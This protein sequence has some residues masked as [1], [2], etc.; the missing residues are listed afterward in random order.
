MLWSFSSLT[1]FLCLISQGPAGTK[2]PEGRQ[3]EKGTKVRVQWSNASRLFI[4]FN[5]RAGQ[6]SDQ[7]LSG[8]PLF[9]GK[10]T[11]LRRHNSSILPPF[12]GTNTSEVW[13]SWTYNDPDEDCFLTDG[14]SSMLCGSRKDSWL[15]SWPSENFSLR[16]SLSLCRETPALSVPQE[17]RALWGP[18]DSQE[19]PE[20]RV[21]GAS[22][23]PWSVV[24]VDS[25]SVSSSCLFCVWLFWSYSHLRLHS[26]HAGDAFIQSD[27]Q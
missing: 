23:D 9:P 15:R 18:R 6:W 7:R 13:L 22:L 5:L 19:S 24:C 27:L 25:S 16:C 8:L 11:L 14:G 10:H 21:L 2:G 20:P 1:L 3:G 4:C 17:R 26:G 12:F